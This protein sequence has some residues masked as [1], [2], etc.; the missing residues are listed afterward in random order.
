MVSHRHQYL[1]GD[2]AIMTVNSACFE[3]SEAWDFGTHSLAFS[4]MGF[5]QKVEIKLVDLLCVI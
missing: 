2:A 5:H 4:N 1:N 3:I